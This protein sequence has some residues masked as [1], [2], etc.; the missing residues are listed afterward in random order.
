VRAQLEHLFFRSFFRLLLM[1]VAFAQ[2]AC[3]AWVLHRL[4]IDLPLAVH[5]LSIVAIFVANRRLVS[6]RSGSSPDRVNF[7][8]YARGVYA[9]LAFTTIFCGLFLI[10]AGLLYIVLGSV[11]APEAALLR[12]FPRLVDLGLIAIAGVLLFGYTV[13]QRQLHV[14]R[15][16]VPVESLPSSLDGL[17]IVHVSDLHIGEHLGTAELERHVDR[18]NALAPDLICL[19][20]DLVDHA[21]TCTVAFPTLARLRARFGVVVT[22]GNHDFHA[23]AEAVTRHLRN[24]TP[25]MVLRNAREVLEVEGGKL[26]LIGVDD[27]GRDWARGVTEHP[28]L[29]PLARGVPRDE[30]MVVLSHRPECF[31]QAVE[32][33]AALMLSGHTHGGQLALPGRGGRRRPNLARFISR[34][35]RGLYVNAGSTLYVNRGLGF[36][37][38]KIR[39]FTPREIALIVLRSIES[40][41]RVEA[42]VIS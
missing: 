41:H 36:T 16:T 11:L 38:Q 20:G 28:A 6:I 18:I 15:V 5:V 29:P 27:L 32:L 3:V 2:W 24:L 42:E 17:R 34:F 23:G 35:D 31:E 40:S 1:F 13:G 10:V 21:D 9:A 7:F 39:L 22:L 12:Q 37:G 25:F 8:G 19:T 30:P 26:H 33:G 4:G 14:S